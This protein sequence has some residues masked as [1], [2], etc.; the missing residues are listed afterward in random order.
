ML[1]PPDVLNGVFEF[2][3]SIF[4]WMNVR[5]VV[6]DK[7]H[8]GIY[9]PAIVFFMSWGLWNLFYYPYLGQLISFA[10]GLS[11]VVANMVWVFCLLY[12]GKKE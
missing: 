3:G 4:T 5:Q 11:L 6:K 1:V 12:F 8:R 9:V 2:I 10:G 7:G